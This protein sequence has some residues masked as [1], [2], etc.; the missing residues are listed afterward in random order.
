[1][2]LIR[3]RI[4]RST[5]VAPRRKPLTNSIQPP[6][7]TASALTPATIAITASALTTGRLTRRNL[8]RCNLHYRSVKPIA[9]RLRAFRQ[10]IAAA[11]STTPSPA[12]PPPAAAI[13]TRSAFT[14]LIALT[15]R[16]AKTL[17]R[18]RNRSG[19]K[20]T[21]WL[22][23]HFIPAS[24]IPAVTIP[25]PAAISTIPAPFTRTLSPNRRLTLNHRRSTFF[26]GA[27]TPIAAASIAASAR[28]ISGLKV[29]RI[30]RLFHEVGDVKKRVP[31][32]A[33]VHKT[34]LHTR[35]HPCYTAVV[36]RPRKRVFVLTL[37]I[38]LR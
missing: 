14:N 24:A 5:T 21:L 32:Q 19:H 30:A 18:G 28:A 17:I 20:L 9:H 16:T 6:A 2:A 23:A 36:N 15:R 34:G 22:P 11:T 13:G 29:S 7:V 31:F 26:G 4:R 38:N 12:S 8:R 33:D 27:A 35:K 1:M 25:V 3:G 37:V 10:L